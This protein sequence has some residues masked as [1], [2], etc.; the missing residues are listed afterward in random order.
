MKCPV[1]ETA[2]QMTEREG[3]EID[4]GPTCRGLWLDRGELDQIIER[5]ASHG[6][7]GDQRS[8]DDGARP[9]R[10]EDDPARDERNPKRGKTK[11]RLS[12]LGDLLGGGE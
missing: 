11:D 4:Y 1:D 10:E 12:F 6:Y 7:D 5:A 9:H 8:S 3:V 2:L